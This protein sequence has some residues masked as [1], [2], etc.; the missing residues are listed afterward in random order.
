MFLLF[1]FDFCFETLRQK[2]ICIYLWQIF[3]QLWEESEWWKSAKKNSQVESAD[4]LLCP[5]LELLLGIAGMHY[6]SHQGEHDKFLL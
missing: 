3:L 2:L 4:V 1:F 6:K 5:S